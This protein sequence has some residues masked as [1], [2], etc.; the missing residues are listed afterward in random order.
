M[1]TTLNESNRSAVDAIMAP[2]SRPRA[3]LSDS[4]ELT[5]TMRRMSLRLVVSELVDE[6]NRRLE[7][8]R[9]YLPDEAVAWML[10]YDAETL[11]ADEDWFNGI[12]MVQEVWNRYMP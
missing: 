8:V 4:A 11:M 9:E 12:E 1:E 7:E 6:A 2:V 3:F 10:F 5:N